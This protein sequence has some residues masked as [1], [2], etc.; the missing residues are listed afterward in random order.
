[1]ELGWVISSQ[2]WLPMGTRKGGDNDAFE[3]LSRVCLSAIR[4]A[5]YAPKL[6]SATVQRLWPG[7]PQSSAVTRDISEDLLGR[8][9]PGITVV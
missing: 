9:F 7:L 8:L 4:D 2:T 3:L 5:V 6:P 1:M